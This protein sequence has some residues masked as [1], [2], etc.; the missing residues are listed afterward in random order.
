[1]SPGIPIFSVQ[2]L[3]WA[4]AFAGGGCDYDGAVGVCVAEPQAEYASPAGLRPD[5][6]RMV[7]DGGRQA[8][9]CMLPDQRTL[10]VI[11]YFTAQLSGIRF[12][13]DV[14][15]ESGYGAKSVTPASCCHSARLT[16]MLAHCP[17]SWAFRNPSGIFC[18]TKN[19]GMLLPSPEDAGESMNLRSPW[20]NL[21]D[22]YALMGIYGADT[23]YV[24]RHRAP[25]G[26]NRDEFHWLPLP[27]D[28]PQEVFTTDRATALISDCP[29]AL[30]NE[31]FRDRRM[32]R[33][34]GG[35]TR[36]VRAVLLQGRDGAQ[37]LFAACFAGGSGH[38]HQTIRLP[39]GRWLRRGLGPR[40]P[41]HDEGE[42]TLRHGECR[43][44]MEDGDG[45]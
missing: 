4:G 14:D 1:M 17:A 16:A 45:R 39:H 40:H 5:S 18:F 37:Y 26:T 29:V 10:L 20:V 43:L 42:Q 33:Y 11:E 12:G 34:T 22:R 31:L 24:L 28:D 32:V 3:W 6:C 38:E 7:C 15:R 35:C 25:D 21:G 23:F 9:V 2:E 41:A 30:Q 27:G 36:Q 13:A 8:A 44:W 19:G